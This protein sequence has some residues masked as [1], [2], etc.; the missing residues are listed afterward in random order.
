MRD[1]VCLVTDK[2]VQTI[3]AVSVD[4]AVTDPLTSA[5]TILSVSISQLDSHIQNDI[6][7]VDIRDDLEGG[8][9]TIL[10]S[11][12]CLECSLVL[13]AREAENVE[14]VFTSKSDKLAAF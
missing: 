5:D 2:V 14:C 8:F 11:L 9:N 3:S 13:L 12:A 10:V 6:P 7:L 4:E 1:S